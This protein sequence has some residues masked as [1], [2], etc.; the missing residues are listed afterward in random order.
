VVV[1]QRGADARG[2]IYCRLLG[3]AHKEDP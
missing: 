3:Q 2:D 1:L